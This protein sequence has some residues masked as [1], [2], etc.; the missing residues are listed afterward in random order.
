MRTAVQRRLVKSP[1]L[2]MGPEGAFKLVLDVEHPTPDRA[3][4]NQDRYVDAQEG[5]NTDESH[6]RR[7][8]KR[9]RRV[10]RHGAEPGMPV[11]MQLAKRQPLP[12]DEKIGGPQNEHDE[13]MAIQAIAEPTPL[14]QRQ[15]LAHSQGVDIAGAAAREIS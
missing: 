13:R 12:H 4:H 7:R 11:S 5:P 2:L 8:Q 15:V 10:R 1:V 9:D 3:R 6:H 14:G